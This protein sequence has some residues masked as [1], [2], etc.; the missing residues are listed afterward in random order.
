MKHFDNLKTEIKNHKTSFLGKDPANFIVSYNHKTDL[1]YIPQEKLSQFYD[2]YSNTIYEKNLAKQCPEKT[3]KQKK[4]LKSISTFDICQIKNGLCSP[5]T[6]KLKC[7]NSKSL[8][9]ESMEKI[10][11][12]YAATIR[13][14]ITITKPE[15]FY[16]HVY[17]LSTITDTFT[18]LFPHVNI[19]SKQ[20]KSSHN[21]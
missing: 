2:I 8:G 1:V 21:W 19:S 12:L 6:L 13:D 3:E 4:F 7:C 15:K 10:I 11:S 9:T 17:G 5:A 18:V 16:C 14:Q 20:Q